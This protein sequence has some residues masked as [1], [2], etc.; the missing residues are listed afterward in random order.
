MDSG[1]FRDNIGS[2]VGKFV[3]HRNTFYRALFLL[4]NDSELCQVIVPLF[5]NFFQGVPE[6]A[7]TGFLFFC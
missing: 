2:F 4:K 5:E 3:R 6:C 1:V 7:S